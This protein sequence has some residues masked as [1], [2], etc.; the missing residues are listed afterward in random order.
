MNNFIEKTNINCDIKFMLSD[1]EYILNIVGWPEPQR[2]D[3][4]FYS[5]NQ[6]CLKYRKNA[7]FPLLDGIGSL[8]DKE[9]DVMIG[10]ES[11]F[12]EYIDIIPEYTKNIIIN[13]EEQLNVK[14]GRIRLMRL[15]PKTGLSVHRDTET[16]YHFVYVTNSNAFF[17]EKTNGDVV[18]N[19]YNIPVDGYFYKVDT[20]REHFVY[21]GG[22]EPRIH[23][24]C[25]TLNG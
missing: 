23:L 16:R 12:T 3:D 7:K 22:W 17:G 25:N 18:A 20:T 15:M 21:N 10:Q 24:V 14:F 8:Y 6:I 5:G 11:D 1:L 19:C 4:K 13:L 9:N 2:L